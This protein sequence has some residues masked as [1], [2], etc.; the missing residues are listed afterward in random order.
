ML[1]GIQ[2][3]SLGLAI[4]S[5][6]A[7]QSMSDKEVAPQRI[8][9]IISDIFNKIHHDGIPGVGVVTWPARG[10]DR[11]AKGPAE[12]LGPH[13][14]NGT[15]GI[16]LFCS[17]YYALTGES[18]ARTVALQSIAPLRATAKRIRAEGNRT[19]KSIA[20]GGLVGLGS[21]LYTFVRMARWLQAADLLASACDIAD[22]LTSERI[23]ADDRFDVMNGCAGT[24]LA[25]LAFEAD[26]SISPAERSHAL[27]LAS[28]CGKHLVRQRSE[29]ASGLRAWGALDRAPLSGF[30]HG[31]AGI[32]YSL[33]RLFHRTGEEQLREA[34]I[35]GFAFEHELYDPHKKTWLDLR[36]N[37]PVEQAA[38]CHGA[39]GIALARIGCVSAVADRFVRDDLEEALTITR[40]LP[41]Y[42]SD[43]LCCGNF[44]RL[45][46][47]HTAGQLLDRH[48]LVR[49]SWA[50]NA[51]LLDRAPKAG[52]CFGQ[53][54]SKNLAAS[55]QQ[56]PLSLFMGLAGV[57]Y[58]L[59]RI[60]FPERFPCLL[61][62]E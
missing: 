39:P 35:E 56:P 50:L 8:A 52:F 34:A 44:G 9:A 55:G 25:L 43:H 60:L 16:A 24:L 62:L 19:G 32:A 21:F 45:E 47:I 33:V 42:P 22:L 36:F 26:E 53:R 61:L 10:S 13:L 48:D 6:Y 2:G 49:E 58:T 3:D 51:H 40:A 28:V 46:I 15:A 57:G 41:E 23:L 37:R 30:A 20:I 1:E 38:W 5:P 29:S 59:T 27:E 7:A 54:D 18:L 11:F 12:M 17:S 14:Y 31:A 4:Q